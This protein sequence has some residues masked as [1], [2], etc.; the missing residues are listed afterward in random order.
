MQTPA[1]GDSGYKVSLDKDELNTTVH[2]VAEDLVAIVDRVVSISIDYRYI[3]IIPSE[4]ERK[5][6]R[7]T[8]NVPE[9]FDLLSS[10]FLMEELSKAKQN[11]LNKTILY[12]LE[13]EFIEKKFNADPEM[14]EELNAILELDPMP[15][16][17]EDEKMVKLQNGGVTQDDYIVSCNIASFVNRAASET[18]DFYKLELEKQREILNGYAAEVVKANS[19]SAGIQVEP[20]PIE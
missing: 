11:N 7:P 14:R 10:D 1:A 4:N 2:A 13:K 9:R 16:N 17:T 18:T 15:Y 5:K 20:P 6:L 12:G 8:I 3:K 19:A